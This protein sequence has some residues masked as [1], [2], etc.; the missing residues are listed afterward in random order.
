MM[1]CVVNFYEVWEYLPTMEI[2]W[3]YV[4]FLCMFGDHVK[5][6]CMLICVVLDVDAWLFLLDYMSCDGYID[7]DIVM[8]RM[9]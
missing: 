3:K 9:T 1:I 2:M 5:N 4:L 8:Y 6:D 7:D